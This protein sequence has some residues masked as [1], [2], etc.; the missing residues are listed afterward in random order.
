M[1]TP[2]TAA[3][4]LGYT[5]TYYI[6]PFLGSPDIAKSLLNY[7][8]IAIGRSFL[9]WCPIKITTLICIALKAIQ[10]LKNHVS[11]LQRGHVDFLYFQNILRIGEDFKGYIH[12]T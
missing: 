2:K 12:I 10:T 6:V 5:P 3:L 1:A 7:L 11:S 4:P 8:V 9:D